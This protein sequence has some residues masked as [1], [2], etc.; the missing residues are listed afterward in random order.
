MD[1]RAT[2]TAKKLTPLK[3]KHI[4]SPKTEMRIPATEGPTSL[5]PLKRNEFKAM[6]FPRSSLLSIISTT[7]ACRLG[8]SKAFTRPRKMERR[9]R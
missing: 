3:R 8:M 1:N 2:M 5:A 9:M 7:K 4:P 6:A